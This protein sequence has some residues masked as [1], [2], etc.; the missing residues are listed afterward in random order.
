[1]DP[2]RVALVVIDDMLPLPKEEP[3]NSC[4]SGHL[5]I[6]STVP[7]GI[8]NLILAAQDG[9]SPVIYVVRACGCMSHGRLGP[10]VRW[11]L[12]SS[13]S[14]PPDI[15]AEM[16]GRGFNAFY[17][18]ELDRI[19]RDYGLSGLVITGGEI[20]GS[21]FH[22]A[23]EAVVRG[24]ETTVVEDAVAGTDRELHNA[25][26]QLLRLYITRV[27]SVREVRARYWMHRSQ[28][29]GGPRDEQ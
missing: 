25:S 4:K 28:T 22:T 12:L 19:S 8:V 29:E 17:K 9:G 11:R 18:T 23:R 16:R 13:A 2:R 3:T 27:S 7:C 24:Y 15:I 1:M 21:V 6:G 10:S 26:L 20:Y 14:S 5:L